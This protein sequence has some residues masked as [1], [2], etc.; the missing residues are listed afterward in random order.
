[1]DAGAASYEKRAQSLRRKR[2]AA[3]HRARP[4][5]VVSASPFHRRH[6]ASGNPEAGICSVLVTS[7]TLSPTNQHLWLG[8]CWQIKHTLGIV[9]ANLQNT[10]SLTKLPFGHCQNIDLSELCPPASL[11][12]PN[13]GPRALVVTT[14]KKQ[15]KEQAWMF[16]MSLVPQRG[17]EHQDQRL[18]LVPLD[19]QPLSPPSVPAC[20]SCLEVEY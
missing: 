3:R 17:M 8:V 18:S 7:P 2:P 20:P 11:C 16:Q 12:T 13:P 19:L 1:M 9:S 4:Q 5:A 6:L 10:Q 15:R 14:D